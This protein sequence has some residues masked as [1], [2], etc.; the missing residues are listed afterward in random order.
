MSA[1]IR[2]GQ[3]SAG[4]MPS[5]AV[6]SGLAAAAAE[7]R[8]IVGRSS[9]A[10][11]AEMAVISGIISGGKN[12]ISLGRCLE[13]ELFFASRL[14]G[15]GLCI[16]VKDEPAVRLEL[17]EKGGLPL[18]S[19]KENAI[20]SALADIKYPDRKI[21]EGTLADGSGF[22]EI[23]R[24]HIEGLIPKDCP[25]SI[26]ISSS[27]PL[28]E[29]IFISRN[30]PEEL[31]LQLSPD[32]KKSALFSRKCG[33]VS[34]EKLIFICCGYIFSK[35]QDAALPFDFTFAAE[36][37]AKTRGRRV[38]R[39][40]SSGDGETD[41]TARR[42]A[43][44]QCFT[45]DGL[46]LAAKVTGILCE[47]GITLEQAISELPDFYTAKRFVHAD[48]RRIKSVMHSWEGRFTPDGASFYDGKGR[49][50]A[51]PSVSGKGIWLS[52]E[53]RSMETA[54]ELCGEIEEQIKHGEES[55]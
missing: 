8:I 18:S 47:K 36:E 33:F 54:S 9:E 16:Y 52:V 46:F 17:K 51:K 45:L 23:Y 27:S 3:I 20:A 26:K 5:E 19:S 4:F 31:V 29:Q 22:R 10:R 34:Y 50:I 44:N 42:L 6:C 53:S 40:Y 11:A 41:K 12:V 2:E 43:K 7:E 35:G 37:Y 48:S 49:V 30:G 15:C 28:C 1:V 39:Y 24:Q 55:L 14:A 13:T 32:G 21:P 38:Y 25:Y